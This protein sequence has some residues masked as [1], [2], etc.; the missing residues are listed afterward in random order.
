MPEIKIFPDN[1][2]FNQAV[3]DRFIEQAA[4]CIQARNV[5]TVALSGGSTPAQIYAALAEEPNRDRITWE[6]VH[7]FWGDERHVPPEDA[8]S[9]YRM[10]REVLLEKVA[11][12]PEN[13]HRVLAELDVHQAADFYEAELRGFFE[14]KQPRFDL[15]LLGMGEDGHT[16]SLFPH[17]TGLNEER[18][19]F[20]ANQIPESGVWRLTL[21]YPA[22]NAAR[23]ILV[24][25]KGVG[26]AD[27]LKDVLTGAYDPVAQPIQAIEPKKGQIV[28][29]LDQAAAEGLQPTFRP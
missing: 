6:K 14:G 20:I 21:T 2:L 7:L 15:A 28:W 25:V 19:W 23:L 11:I 16:A 10:V 4:L 24:L 5:F 12:P 18:R 26:K 3:V 13:V 22:I 9:N 29:M 27:R 8:D 1:E 17:S